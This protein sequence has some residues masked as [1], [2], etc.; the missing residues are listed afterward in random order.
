MQDYVSPPWMTEPKARADRF[1]RGAAKH[2]A[3]GAYM[4]SRALEWYWTH[5][6]IESIRVGRQAKK[7]FLSLAGFQR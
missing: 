6:Q 1:L 3:D 4:F 7:R 2:F 5:L